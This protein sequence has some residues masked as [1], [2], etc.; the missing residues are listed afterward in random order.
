MKRLG[1]VTLVL[2]AAVAALL[3]LA[4][5][6]VL[7]AAASHANAEFSLS[8]Q[9]MAEGA[10]L[11]EARLRDRSSGAIGRHLVRFSATV[12][13]LGVRP[14]LLGT[15]ETDTS[16]TARFTYRPTWNGLH[17]IVARTSFDDG[18][19]VSNEA[20]LEVADAV[21]PL[22]PPPAR[23]TVVGAW[24]GPV[25]AGIALSVSG[26]LVLVLL[27]VVLGIS[28]ASAIAATGGRAERQGRFSKR[29]L[30]R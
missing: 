16:G 15:G 7:P 10:W 2:S 30:G 13:F 1:P 20:V 23:L 22:A 19:A 21:S 28:R 24:A 6:P 17:R 9:P 29:L 14:V 12:E 25:A 4:L 5:G 26:L 11:L 27:R 8:A 18:T 3:V